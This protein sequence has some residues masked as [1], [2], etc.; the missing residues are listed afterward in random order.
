VLAGIGGVLLVAGLFALLRSDADEFVAV[1]TTSAAQSYRGTGSDRGALTLVVRDG[2]TVRRLPAFSVDGV[3]VLALAGT[4]PATATVDVAEGTD[5]HPARVVQLDRSGLIVVTCDD[6]VPRAPLGAAV[7]LRPGDPV[8]TGTPDGT[9]GTIEATGFDDGRPMLTVRTDADAGQLLWTG[10]RLVGVLLD[11]TGTTRRAVPVEIAE[12]LTRATRAGVDAGP[13]LGVL[14]TA[15][16]DQVVLGA[17]TP[18]SPAARAGL[19]PGDVVR[20]IDDVSVGSPWQFALELRR[21][22]PGATVTVT[23]ERAGATLSVPVTLAAR[24]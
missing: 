3:H 23:V 14:T 1:A 19:Q 8:T 10:G 17:V 2:G 15:G 16:T 24:A 4:V 22:A 20:R 5:R 9:R 21:H 18:D 6:E 11:G 12:G 13:V 7:L